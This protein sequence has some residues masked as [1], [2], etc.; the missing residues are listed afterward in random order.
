MHQTKIQFKIELNRFF[1]CTKGQKFKSSI[2]SWSSK[3]SNEDENIIKF[4]FLISI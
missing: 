3:I 2:V 1:S 4:L